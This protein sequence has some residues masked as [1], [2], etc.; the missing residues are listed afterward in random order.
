ML[1]RILLVAAVG[2][3]GNRNHPCSRALASRL[4]EHAAGQEIGGFEAHQVVFADRSGGG[5]QPVGVPEAGAF[6]RIA[7]TARVREPGSPAITGRP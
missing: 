1:V 7:D 2:G 6:Q 3:G 4:G 5:G